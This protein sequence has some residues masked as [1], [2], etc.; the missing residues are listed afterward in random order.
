VERNAASL[1]LWELDD[2]GCAISWDRDD[3]AA[4]AMLFLTRL[5]GRLLNVTTIALTYRGD[6]HVVTAT[7][8]EDFAARLA[9][10]PWRG[11]FQAQI[12][13]H[14]AVL[15]ELRF[16]PCERHAMSWSTASHDPELHRAVDRAIEDLTAL[17][18]VVTTDWGG[19][20]Q[21]RN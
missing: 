16:E 14:D 2:R 8:A 18:V 20:A 7:S 1:H 5:A 10:E 9:G 21:G 19:G 17:G 11:S 13:H 4:T 12:E 15:F 6:A 3:G